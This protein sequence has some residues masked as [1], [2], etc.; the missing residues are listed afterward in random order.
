MS[1]SLRK[2]IS[3]LPEEIRNHILSYTHSPQSNL[4]LNDI[5]H[6]LASLKLLREIYIMD[7]MWNWDMEPNAHNNWLENNIFPVIICGRFIKMH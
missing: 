6:Y 7:F 4:L 2:E 5:K 3:G 1:V